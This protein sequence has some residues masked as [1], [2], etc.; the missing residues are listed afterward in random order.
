MIN[1]NIEPSKMKTTQSLFSII[2]IKG[3]FFAKVRIYLKRTKANEIDYLCT[4]NEETRY[5]SDLQ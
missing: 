5:H 4:R 3:I 2:L 1:T